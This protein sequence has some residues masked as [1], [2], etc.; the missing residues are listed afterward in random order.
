MGLLDQLGKDSKRGGLDSLSRNSSSGL[1]RLSGNSRRSPI[2]PEMQLEAISGRFRKQEKERS[3]LGRVVHNA[4]HDVTEFLSGMKEIAGLGGA[5]MWDLGVRLPYNAITL[6][7]VAVDGI[8]DHYRKAPEAIYDVL[9]DE[10]SRVAKVY[11]AAAAYTGSLGQVGSLDPLKEQFAEDPIF[12]LL[13]VA[14]FGKVASAPARIASRKLVGGMVKDA[15]AAPVRRALPGSKAFAAERVE[16]LEGVTRYSDELMDMVK[17][18]LPEAQVGDEIFT[19]QKIVSRGKTAKQLI[20]EGTTDGRKLALHEVVN[21]SDY[22]G[23]T[24]AA[25]LEEVR[26][27]T[28]IMGQHVSNLKTATVLNK[29]D[30]WTQT[31]TNPYRLAWKTLGKTPG[32]RR[33]REI[34]DNKGSALTTVS[35]NSRTAGA[36][37]EVYLRN[38]APAISKFKKLDPETSQ[39]KVI[40]ALQSVS[41]DIDAL[42]PDEFAAYVGLKSVGTHMRPRVVR[43]MTAKGDLTTA[44]ANAILDRRLMANAITSEARTMLDD[45]SG[46]T[47]VEQALYEKLSDLG[48]T[49]NM[50]KKGSKGLQEEYTALEHKQLYKTPTQADIDLLERKALQIQLTSMAEG[51]LARKQLGFIP[52]QR[53]FVSLEQLSTFT[54]PDFMASA[55]P[56]ISKLSVR[57]FKKKHDIVMDALSMEDNMLRYVDFV[58]H[59]QGQLKLLDDVK[60]VSTRVAKEDI[61]HVLFENAAAKIDGKNIGFDVLE[62]P[63]DGGVIQVPRGMKAIFEKAFSPERPGAGLAAVDFTRNEFAKIVLLMNPGW[64]TYNLLGNIELFTMAAGNPGFLAK[65]TGMKVADGL[66]NKFWAAKGKNPTSRTGQLL[67]KMSEEWRDLVPQSQVRGFTSAET[68]QFGTIEYYHQGER[69]WGDSSWAR[70]ATKYAAATDKITGKLGLGALNEGI[71][72]VFRGALWM[73]TAQRKVAARQFAET[74]VLLHGLNGNRKNLMALADEFDPRRM[75]IPGAT[76]LSPEAIATRDHVNRFLNDYYRLGPVE[77]GLLRRVFP[78]YSWMKFANKLAVELPVNHPIRMSIAAFT[79]N[80]VNDARAMEENLPD[81]IADA[82]E[83][84]EHEDGTTTFH[85]GNNEVFQGVLFGK[86]GFSRVPMGMNPILKMA[87]EFPT[88]MSMMRQQKNRVSPGRAA[89]GLI[90][91]FGGQETY[92]MGEDGMR[93]VTPR[94]SVPLALLRSGLVPIPM[95]RQ[96]EKLIRGGPH[97]DVGSVSELMWELGNIATGQPRHFPG[98]YLDKETQEPYETGNARDLLGTGFGIS[99][100]TIDA[101][102]MRQ[103]EIEKRLSAAKQ[104][105]A[106]QEAEA[107]LYG[108]NQKF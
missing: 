67:K 28:P 103:R 87:I 58:A 11:G 84:Q 65:S 8:L 63:G 66:F 35:A 14:A 3:Y 85:S 33:V 108:D 37:K 17:D 72:E 24:A 102:A 2:N 86:E 90:Q 75:E 44:E 68:R 96:L 32:F 101:E 25:R 20:E 9:S 100:F 89:S 52:G 7:E 80:A 78:F 73:Q 83:I 50:V 59:T 60:V 18:R 41:A 64:L 43:A 69:V 81:W 13:D 1:S 31:L 55:A 54:I 4:P 12:T 42:T 23:M 51:R 6:D 39:P 36:L 79:T 16:G 95:E 40:H 107:L 70:L 97:D 29:M 93:T 104:R 27:L 38:I 77:R 19:G 30:D 61:Q 48:T 26:R 5:A 15:S 62:L 76:K 47:P 49:D 99:R 22:S 88:G 106:Q 46:L 98:A 56:D 82:V 91:S 45:T 10:V 94:P 92:E 21:N 105:Q 57:S 53:D 74:G 71:E 34:L